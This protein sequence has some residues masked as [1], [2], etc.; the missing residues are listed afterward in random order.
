MAVEQPS[1][2]PFRPGAGFVPEHLAGR[3]PEQAS[4]RDALRAITGPRKKDHGPL[5][6]GSP[7]HL[8]IIGTRGMGKMA[9]LDWARREAESLDA[10]FVRL[11]H[12]PNA[13]S[14][15]A[16]SALLHKLA[17]IPGLDRKQISEWESDYLQWALDWQP[18]KPEL[19]FKRVLGTR[20]RF[21]PLMLVLDDVMNYDMDMLDLVLNQYQL[22]A[23]SGWP[24]ALVLVGTPALDW[25]LV[26]VK[27]AF[28]YRSDD[29]YI[30]CLDPAATREALSKPFADRGVKLSDEALELMLSWTDDY[31]FFIQIVGSAVWE[32]MEDAERTEVDVALVQSVE[33]VVQGKRN[34]FYNK[35]YRK[36]DNADLDEQAMKVV[37]VIEAVT[38]PLEP[39]QIRTCLAEGTALKHEGALKIYKHLLDAGLFWESEDGGV[40]AAIPSFFTYFKK[41]YKQG[42]KRAKPSPRS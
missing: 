28:I 40:S 5:R 15:D 21:R 8:K 2:N 4:L 31:P 12:E 13:D 14:D 25:Y 26:N 3:E 10:D 32:A 34:A 9:L 11:T 30:H 20:L 41:R 17:D 19:D 27:A 38:H 36:I 22:L 37:N 7:P 33:K 23:S 6:G 1:G 29:I 39:K 18:G 35:I 42:R 24:L 16:L